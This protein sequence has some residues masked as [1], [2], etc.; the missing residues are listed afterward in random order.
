MGKAAYGIISRVALW[1]VLFT[2]LASGAASAEYGRVPESAID[3]SKIKID[4]IKYLGKK[5]NGEMALVDQD[6]VRFNLKDMFGKPLILVLS[7]YSCDGV[8]STVNSDLRDVLAKA[9]KVEIGKDFNVLTI[10]FDKND[11][12]AT[13]TNFRKDLSLPPNQARAWKHALAIN[14]QDAG[15]LA[16]GIGFKYFWSPSDRVFLHPNLYIFISADGRVVRYLSASSVGPLDVEVAVMEAARGDVSPSQLGALLVSYCYSYN[17]KVG[18]YTLNLP[19]FIGLGS[20]AV[21]GIS[22]FIASI[23]QKRKKKHV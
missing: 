12:A 13:V 14:S 17:Y 8:C 11:T 21:G 9:G 4:E 1:L 22:F 19:I 23:I 7:Y 10:S 2:A 6:G 15:D 5:L 20:L 3:L 18:K 16:A